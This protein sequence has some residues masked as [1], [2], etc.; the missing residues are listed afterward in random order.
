[1]IPSPDMAAIAILAADQALADVHEGR[2]STD[3]QPGGPAIRIT[4]LPGSAPAFRWEWRGTIQADC[5][6][7]DQATA[8]D[9]A[10]LVRHQ[11]TDYTGQ[12]LADLGA[13]VSGCWIVTDPAWVGDPDTALGR[14]TLT[15]GLAVH[16][17]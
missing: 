11:W 2:V 7:A 3:L 9:L 5:F 1:M 10:A 14:Y 8:A 4:L 17:H 6:A 15:L 12:V 16:E 13:Y